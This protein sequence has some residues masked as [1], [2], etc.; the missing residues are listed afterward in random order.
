MPLLQPRHARPCRARKAQTCWSACVST[1]C[2]PAWPALLHTHRH[3]L[4]CSHTSLQGRLALGALLLLFQAIAVVWRGVVEAFDWVDAALFLALRLALYVT[5]VGEQAAG[6]VPA[7]APAL[8]LCLSRARHLTACLPTAAW[9]PLR[10]AAWPPPR[11]CAGLQA[12]SLC[13]GAYGAWVGLYELLSANP[14]DLVGQL[15]RGINH[16]ALWAQAQ[17]A[18][19]PT[20]VRLGGSLVWVPVLPGHFISLPSWA[21]S[22]NSDGDGTRAKCCTAGLGVPPQT[23]RP[24]LA[25]RLCP[26]VFHI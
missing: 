15:S 7:G 9:P 10:L 3:S 20:L 6:A 11:P 14:L 18:M 13:C 23:V 1:T 26:R 24:R 16:A 21:V 4:A 19:Q 8:K 25:K 12:A 17:A 5:A 2:L 22:A